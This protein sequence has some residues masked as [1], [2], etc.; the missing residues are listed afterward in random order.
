MNC[1]FCCVFNQE[2]YIDMF[3]L[4]LESIFI[5][6]VEVYTNILVYTST[7]FMNIIKQS[8]LF[9]NDKIIFE[10]ND[11]Y[12]NI[13][14]ACKARLDLFNLPSII[15][16]SKILYLD[17]DILVKDN[18]NELFNVCKED[19]LYVLEEGDLTMND[20]FYGGKTLFG[21]EINNYN[22]KSAFTSGILLFNNCEKIKDLFNKINED[23]VNR[24]NNFSCHDQ[25]YIVYNAFKY[26]LYNNKI[27]KSFAVN[28]D[29]NINSDK[30][31]HHFPGGP[32]IY[33]HKIEAMTIFLNSMKDFTINNNI[34]IAKQ[35]IDANLLKIINNCGELLEG[36]IFMLH[37]TTKYTNVYLNKAKNISNVVLNKNIKNVIEIGFN[38]GFSTLLILLTNPNI[39]ISCFDL[40]EHKYTLPCYEK[41]KE[42]FGERI[43][44]TFGDS[45]KTLLNVTN[46][47][48]L[49]H[50]D[51]GH[52]LEVAN[53][54]I[55]NSY[56]LSKKGTILIMDD[57]DFPILHNIW[58]SYVIKYNLKK[59]NIN[60]YNSPHH[61]IKYVCAIN[62]PKILF[63]TNKTCPDAYVLDMI[64]YRLNPDWKYE[65]YNDNDVI[66]FF[67]DNPITD[68]P[69][70]IQKYNSIIKGAHKADLFR[71][72]Y[73]YINGG[74]FMDSDAMLY[75]DIDTIVKN[76]NF[77]SVNSSNHPGLI[78]QGIL[79][80]SPKNEIIK[81][82]LY[83]A[84]NTDPNILES[85]Y[86]YF[87]KQLY[88]IIK[89]NDF[90]YNIK[91]YE[92]RRMKINNYDDILDKE[93][94]LF[95]HYWKNKVIPP[96]NTTQ[97]TD[98]FTKIYNTNYWIKGSGS[99][100]YIENTIIYNK[101]ISD[102]IKNNNI[103]SITDIGCGD[104]Q[105]SYLIY[106]QFD[107][108]DY[109]GLDC[110][111]SV[112]EN[113]KKN[114]PKYSF[115][116]LDILCNID[117]IRDSDLYII[118]D[119]LQH[120]KLVDI[121]MFLDK[122]VTKK[123]K[124]IIITN[125]A[126]QNNDDL[127]LNNIGNGR[128]LHSNFLPLK[129]YNAQLLIE[130]FG[131]ENKHMCIIR[132]DTVIPKNDNLICYDTKYG[133]IFLNKYDYYMVDVFS[134]NEY[135]DDKQ[136][137]ILRDKYIPTD[138]NILE[139]GGHSGT[140]TIFYSKILKE[141]NIIYTFEPQKQMFAILNKNIEINNLNS[142]IK[143]FNSAVFCK[144]GQINMHCEDMDGPSKG[145]IKIL[146]SENKNINYGGICLGKNGE[147]TNCIKLDDLDF[148]NIGYIHCDAQ[149]A[150]PFIFSAAT[151][152]IKKHRPVILY[153]DINLYGNYLFN[154]I[155]SSYPEFINNSEFDIKKYCI[156][157]LGYY[158]ISN[159]NNS[160]FDSLL[161]P[162]L[163]TD[164]NNYNKSELNKFD[165]RILN[166]YK[167]PN[168]F[169]RVGPKQDGGY[170]IADGF[171]Y[172]FFISCGIANDI[173][174]EKAFLDIHKIKC[175]AF[176]G[177]IQS[178]PRHRNNMEW[179]PKNIGF[180][181]TD[182]TTNLK[183]YI[184]TNKKIFLKMDIEGSE[185]NWLDSMTETELDNFSQ[186]VLEVHWSFDIYR[187]NMLKKL[188]KTH[189]IIHIHGNN[190][191]GTVTINNDKIPQIKLPEVFE[192]TYINKKLCDYSLI[193]IEE[194]QFPTVLD[195]PNNPN[196]DDI[197][198]SI[199]IYLS[200]ENKTYTWG[201]SYIKFL[202]HFKMDAFGE[203]HYSFINSKNI[204]A[205]F[206]GRKH[207]IIF[208]D[209]YTSFTSTRKDDL[210]IVNGKLHNI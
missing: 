157:E 59:L 97:Y 196:A 167:I 50:I 45:T 47:Y 173:R 127:E 42:T 65:F 24:P 188:N 139:I 26:N 71:Y 176:D 86:H 9:N 93:T 122:L 144:T 201:N 165:Y 140:S 110:V 177:T 3:F 67:I 185:F 120:W 160:G 49:I 150:E 48:D 54:D 95:K 61:D 121:Y 55:T 151:Q 36:N 207:N 8:H 175:V 53:S 58:D 62:I 19:L 70:I 28:N 88:D 205:N 81:K 85:N 76:Y 77:V 101:Y 6:G 171:E 132:K 64:M 104:W 84:Y 190:Y 131:D 200:L 114:H 35:Y 109:I 179:I 191:G 91:L 22:D 57:Y 135:W 112:I 199:P 74:F 186:I 14:K 32:G 138:K 115:K 204:I 208:N 5:Y 25:P 192:V 11:T 38:A 158:C 75:I 153:E 43:N 117:L 107:N 149:G 152:F 203:G 137:C 174:F 105:S 147:L 142:K 166:T 90:G 134:K 126:C 145:N 172:D 79:G 27:L 18:I 39:H 206:G 96:M 195:Y 123:F 161:L 102:F 87:C 80:A 4:L 41:L 162:Y 180:S 72:Y 103:N 108:I 44:I 197:H 164:W 20:D 7:P 106:Q 111:N 154:I 33:K 163:Y 82:A 130:Y 198:F 52:S 124:Y 181:N 29:N 128:G 116:T 178:F 34:N 17:T 66:Q 30:V 12:D 170:V 168:N 94:V 73:L 15:N 182:K 146:E 46:M 60:L 10:I 133:K 51:G 193:K 13:D 21:N 159:F 98:E 155:K 129:K 56:R 148:E 78:F 194:I 68:L 31:I 125:N 40:G 202:D 209:D 187:M 184:Q 89:E 118:K 37:H 23:I 99:G 83:E 169:V 2:K 16:Y 113:N 141:N 189:Y 210:Q 156:E 136:L 100:S 92:E 69:D 143:T 183:E 119:V 63:Q 1:I